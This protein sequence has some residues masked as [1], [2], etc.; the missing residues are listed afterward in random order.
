[1]SGPSLRFQAGGTLR[2][3]ALYVERPADDE[4]PAALAR[5][6]LCYVLTSRQMGKSSLRVRAAGRLRRAGL[7]C[8]SIDLTSIDSFVFHQRV[9]HLV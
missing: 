6:E 5:G 1:M 9:R 8:A 3:D 4:L 2:E 7:A